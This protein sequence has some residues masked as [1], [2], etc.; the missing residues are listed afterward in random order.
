MFSFEY[1]Y[2]DDE[3]DAPQV[4][5]TDSNG[6]QVLHVYEDPTFIG[7]DPNEATSWKLG[8]FAELVLK[9]LNREKE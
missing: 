9:L 1:D 8:P 3:E 7:G 6:Y 5:I 2:A 4:Y